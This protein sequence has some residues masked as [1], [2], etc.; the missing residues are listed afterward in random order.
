MTQPPIRN[1][2]VSDLLRIFGVGIASILAG[3][4]L[5]LPLLLLVDVLFGGGSSACP[6]NVC[7]SSSP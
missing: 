7:P 5:I 4:L 1:L 3:L 2:R 6:N